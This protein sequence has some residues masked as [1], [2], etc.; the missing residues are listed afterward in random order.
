MT[1]KASDFRDEAEA[2]GPLAGVRV[3]D[4][5]QLVQAPQAAQ[6]LGDMGADVIKVEL[7]GIG[8]AARWIALTAEDRRSAF[9][10]G[11]N[12]G[13]RGI[14]IDLRKPEGRD[15]FLR[16][17]ERTDIVTSNFS[18]GTLDGWGVGYEDLS[19]RNPRVILAQG[20]V[21]G[22]LGPD[23][24]REGADLAGQASGGLVRRMATGADD[25][26]PVAVTI[27]DH[28]GSQN[29]VAGVLAAL[30]ARERT[31]RGQ[32][33][34]VSLLGGQ[35]FAQASEYTWAGLTGQDL[36]PPDQGHP[37]I[38]PVYGVFP[39]A[40]DHIAFLGPP[41][42]RNAAFFEAIGHPEFAD[43]PKYAD[44]V[45]WPEHRKEI[46][47]RYTEIFRTKT[48]DEWVQIFAKL[49]FRYARVRSYGE[50]IADEAVYENGYLQKVLHPEWGEV[51]LPGS[52]VRFSA[53]PATPGQLAPELGQHTEEILLET[54]LTWEEIES[55]KKTGAI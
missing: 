28:L 8:D 6:M 27:A 42:G 13:K 16:L 23:A 29:M 51:T 54:G 43:D 24:H 39:T 49:Q 21:F 35:L 11:C 41:L 36:P 45:I 38:P 10:I 14:T 33:V 26:K 25:L 7:P 55:L 3:V 17:I 9:F 1:Q 47:E 48:T 31:G 32:N 50:V 53:T 5:G 30:H 15:V 46:L 4:V 44:C 12:R 20:N 40:D 22:P 19:A 34:E 37:L 18:A 2:M 52:P